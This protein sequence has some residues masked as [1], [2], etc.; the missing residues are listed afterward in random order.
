MLI[1]MYYVCDLS[2]EEDEINVT[3][4][5]LQYTGTLCIKTTCGPGQSGLN[6]GVVLILMWSYYGVPLY[7]LF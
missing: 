5:E 4:L 6:S 2:L 3:T 7:F 1:S